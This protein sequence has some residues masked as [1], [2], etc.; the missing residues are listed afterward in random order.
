M[1]TLQPSWPS[2]GYHMQKAISEGVRAP[3]SGVS[4]VK[5]PPSFAFAS[6][7]PS[8]WLQFLLLLKQLNSEAYYTTVKTM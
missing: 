2:I 7:R 3:K 4:A 1:A 8:P 5:R 6:E